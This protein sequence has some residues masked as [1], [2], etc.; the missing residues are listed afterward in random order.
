M[1]LLFVVLYKSCF[2]KV[3]TWNY[4]WNSILLHGDLITY[5]V[6]GMMWFRRLLGAGVLRKGGMLYGQVCAGQ[7]KHSCKEKGISK[8]M[9]F[10]H[11]SSS[12]ENVCKLKSNLVRILFQLELL[13]DIAEKVQNYASSKHESKM[14]AMFQRRRLIF[15]LPRGGRW[16]GRKE[17]EEELKS[18]PTISEL[19]ASYS[20]V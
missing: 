7:S 3:I 17:K 8:P 1:A 20:L 18:V 19:N 13:P 14:C 16:G 6:H 4:L 11:T 5:S 15:F 10:S 12:G 2:W 9:F